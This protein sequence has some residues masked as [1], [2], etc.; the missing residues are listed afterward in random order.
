MPDIVHH[1]SDLLVTSTLTG[2]KSAHIKTL[3][4]I[5]YI[6]LLIFK[7]FSWDN[8]LSDSFKILPLKT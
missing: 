1:F 7:T 4:Y 3:L 5:F 6:K 8:F 2:Q